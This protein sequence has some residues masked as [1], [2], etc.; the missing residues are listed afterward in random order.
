MLQRHL[1][2][3]ERV[4]RLLGR[5]GTVIDIVAQE[6]SV[7]QIGRKVQAALTQPQPIESLQEEYAIAKNCTGNNYLPL[8]WKHFKD[9]RAVL[10]RAINALKPVAATQDESLLHTWAVLRDPKNHRRDW[11]PV[12]SLHLRFATKRCALYLDTP[13]ILHSSIDGS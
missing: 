11:I 7:L 2:Q 10:L 4:D 13:Q 6:R 1:E 9:N 5:F 12:E 8:L 3:R